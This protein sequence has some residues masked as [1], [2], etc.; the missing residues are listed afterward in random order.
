MRTLA[1]DGRM[2]AS[3]DMLLAALI[4]A[5][6]DSAVLDP[7]EDALPVSYDVRSVRK[8]GI[9]AT[10]VTVRHA[11]ADE[12]GESDHDHSHSHDDDHSHSHDDDHS[13]SH[14]DDHS[15]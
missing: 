14:D 2:G 9:A 1:F 8:N 5:G 15:H 4:A 12:D 7:V 10:A 6:A 13:H 11:D 3:G